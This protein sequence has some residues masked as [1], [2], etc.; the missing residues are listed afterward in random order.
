MVL[1]VLVDCEDW[2]TDAGDVL[3]RDDLAQACLVAHECLEALHQ[4]DRVMRTAMNDRIDGDVFVWGDWVFERRGPQHTTKWDQERLLSVLRDAAHN[5]AVAQDLD[6][7]MVL[8]HM[9]LEVIP[10]T[11]STGFRV[12]ALRRLGINPDTFREVTQGARGTARV[13]RP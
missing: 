7:A 2:F 10:A 11:S 4:I 6:E 3:D 5:E 8:Y 1:D 13:K 12:Q 9:L